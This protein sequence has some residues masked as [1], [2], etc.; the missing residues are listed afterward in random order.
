MRPSFIPPPPSAAR[1]AT[2][3][4]IRR[5]A[6]ARTASLAAALL[7]VA[8]GTP[9]DP[10]L[11]MCQSLARQLTGDTVASWERTRQDE[12]SRARDI[13]VAYSTTNDQ[14]GSIDCRYPIDP[15]NGSVA[16]APNE[17]RLNGQKVSTRELLAAGTKASG[18]LI[19]GTAADTVA[20]SKELAGEAGEKKAREAAD[21]ALE[22][23]ADGVKTLQEKLDR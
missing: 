5:A 4:V 1:T 8:C 22:V 20:R 3:P 19:A 23:A 17:V 10:Q 11:S 15:Q 12:G 6:A 18:E 21:R 13:S 14:S 7:V 16:T 9:E 2:R